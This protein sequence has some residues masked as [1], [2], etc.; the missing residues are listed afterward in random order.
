MAPRVER[1]LAAILAADVVG[2]SRLVGADEAGTIA[3]L[4]ALRKEF[5]EPL[6][7]EYRG[8]MVKLTGDGALVEFASAVDAVEC[9]VAIQN[10]VAERQAAEPEDRRIAFRVGIN[11]GDIIVEDGDILGDGV[12]I[13]AR[14]E[15]LAE[16]GGVC[17]ARTVYNHVRN[18]LALPFQPMGA[19]RV[20]NIAEPVEVW[21]VALDGV[22]PR[23]R[24]HSRVAPFALAAGVA[25]LLAFGGAG[26]WWWQQGR[27]AVDSAAIDPILAMPTGPSIAVLPFTN[28]TGDP[29]EEYFVDGLTED[30]VTRLSKFQ[31]FRV[32]ARNSTFRYKGQA[33]DVRQV[34]KELGA[35]YIVEGSVRRSPERIRVSAQLVDARDGEHVWSETYDR[36]LTAGDV[37][38]IQDELTHAITSTIGDVQGVIARSISQEARRK[39]AEELTSYECVLRLH[40]YNR[41]IT[42][43]AHLAALE[44]LERTVQT[45]SGYA[46]AWAA[47]SEVY[48]E[49]HALGF[50]PRS[51]ALDLALDAAQRAVALDATSQHAQ[52]ALAYA[53]FQRRDLENYL[54]VVDKVIR[55]NPNDAYYLGY[56]G[57]AVAWSG[58]WGR[59]RALVDKAIKLSPYYPGWW[60]Y[61]FVVQN[62]FEGNYQRA[63]VE[64]QKLDMPDLFWTPM[65]YAA[66]YAQMGRTAEAE[67]QLAEALRQNPDLATRPRHYLGNYIFPAEV[68]EQIMDGLRKAGL[69]DPQQSQDSKA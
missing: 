29:A 19:H 56:S 31:P 48:A 28:L 16:P 12:N 20:K 44:C 45:D 39:P 52:W 59:G 60:H 64:A 37:F 58:Q 33:V 68:I 49:M 23:M 43:E 9:A 40:E 51:N 65:L 13:A 5:I 69:S 14:L 30:I 21:R 41:L 36:D 63:L 32:I 53:Y 7:T 10:G 15:A 42:A 47:L 38:A 11:L 25:A 8:R 34:G 54:G 3:R 62:Y 61:P 46:D 22:A 6:V 55:L 57:W 27:A 26:A 17:V 66:I 18:K 35:N 67:A 50:N 2:Y 4:K 1:K 24:K